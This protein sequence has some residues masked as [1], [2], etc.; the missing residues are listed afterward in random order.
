MV[1]RKIYLMVGVG[2]GQHDVT[3]SA[4]KFPAWH[5]QVLSGRQHHGDVGGSQARG[6]CLKSKEVCAVLRKIKE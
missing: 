6:L 1:C 2:G 5:R 3:K 4:K